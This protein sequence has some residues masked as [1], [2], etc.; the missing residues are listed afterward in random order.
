MFLVYSP[1]SVCILFGSLFHQSLQKKVLHFSDIFDFLLLVILKY[2]LVL[3]W[4]Y[5]L[6]ILILNFI[7]SI[8]ISSDDTSEDTKYISSVSTTDEM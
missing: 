7:S 3:Y 5:C 1:S 8:S 6:Q 2:L 4:T